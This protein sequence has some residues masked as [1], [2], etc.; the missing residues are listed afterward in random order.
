MKD[1]R[2]LRVLHAIPDPEREDIEGDRGRRN[3]GC[4]AATFS[5]RLLLLLAASCTGSRS[6][7]RRVEPEPLGSIP[8]VESWVIQLQGLERPGAIDALASARADLFVLEATRSVR[9]MESFPIRHVL[10]RIRSSNAGAFP[11][12]LLAYV[13]VGQAEDYRT[14]WS[15]RWRAPAAEG[16]ANPD[17]LL[18][19]DP[20]GWPGNFVV[21]Y[22]DERWQQ[23]LFGRADS[24]IDAALADGFDGAYLDWI[25]GYQHPLVLEAARMDA[26]DPEWAMVELIERLGTYARE[27]DDDFMVIAQNALSLAE[28]IPDLLESI[29]GICQEDVSFRGE[30]VGD[31]A[32]PRAGDIE[33]S[34]EGEDGTFA[35]LERLRTVGARGKLVLT[36]DYAGVPANVEVA[37]RRSRQHG[38][39]PFVSRTPLDRLPMES[40][41]P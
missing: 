36:L 30:S 41:R 19:P 14:Y 35:L 15:E 38:L 29:D 7:D 34:G 26:V 10:R 11:C 2:L 5:I 27:Q 13:N 23:V 17:Y 9:G 4:S 32:D 31:W 24:L 21:R 3:T 12:R 8:G 16:T 40:E 25:L 6:R 37:M 18:A 22:W 1:R 33:R 28:E 39:V 20:E